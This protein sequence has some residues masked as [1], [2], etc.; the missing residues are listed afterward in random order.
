[1]KLRS[2]FL[3][4]KAKLDEKLRKFCVPVHVFVDSFIGPTSSFKHE[5]AERQHVSH[6]LQ[7]VG[8]PYEKN[9]NLHEENLTEDLFFEFFFMLI[10]K[11][12]IEHIFHNL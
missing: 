10:S 8:L 7:S 2:I 3:Y 5:Q 9:D 11:S 6:M 4:G 12:E 1:M